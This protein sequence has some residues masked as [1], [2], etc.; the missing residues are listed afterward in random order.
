MVKVYKGELSIEDLALAGKHPKVRTAVTPFS[1]DGIGLKRYVGSAV[2]WK[3]KKC[4]GAAEKSEEE[5]KAALGAPKNMARG[6]KK[7]ASISKGVVGVTGVA[8]AVITG[9]KRIGKR[10]VTYSK[11]GIIP[12]RAALIAEAH[13]K[14]VVLEKTA[15]HVRDLIAP[16]TYPEVI[17]SIPI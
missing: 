5:I 1:M 13:G 9:K 8:L 3:R 7:I 6:V 15:D 17:V 14:T 12:A 4:P 2:G 11:R 10:T 16:A